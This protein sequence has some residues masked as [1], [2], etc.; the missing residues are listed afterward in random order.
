MKKD[1]TR[2]AMTILVACSL[3]LS[4][5]GSIP[6]P[7]VRF[8]LFVSID[9]SRNKDLSVYLYSVACRSMTSG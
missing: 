8:Q 1:L 2:Y 4:G 5:C 3:L 6:I 7:G 9:R